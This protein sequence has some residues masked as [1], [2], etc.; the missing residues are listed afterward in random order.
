MGIKKNIKGKSITNIVLALL[1]LS[2]IILSFSL[3]TTGKDIGEENIP[4]QESPS[5]I[6]VM[7]HSIEDVYQPELIALHGII[8][9]KPLAII[10]SYELDEFLEESVNQSNFTEIEKVEKISKEEYLKKIEK[11]SW[12][13]F[14]YPEE[15]PLGL[16]SSKFTDL[17]DEKA[18]L[19]FDRIIF[20]QY[21]SSKVSFY[22][23]ESESLYTTENINKEHLNID[24]FLEKREDSILKTEAVLLGDTIKYLPTS[25]MDIPYKTY[26]ISQFPKRTY[27]NNFFPDTSLVDVRSASNYTRYIDLTKEVT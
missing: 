14:I 19:F 17:A 23:L 13:E 27:I 20:D 21:N 16:I 15:L 22:H 11:G 9:R 1:V 26:I 6:S 10:N 7:A 8:D 3:W 5:R 4:E 18:D 12:L 2:S 25:S 24:L